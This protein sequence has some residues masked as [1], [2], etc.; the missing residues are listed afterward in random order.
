M[1]LLKI[2]KET[3]KNKNGDWGGNE[4]FTESIFIPNKIFGIK[5]FLSLFKIK[6]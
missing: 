1:Y 5:F 3:N 2:L 6:K 4:Y